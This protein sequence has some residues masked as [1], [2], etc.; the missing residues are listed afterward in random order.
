MKDGSG[1]SKINN[2]KKSKLSFPPNIFRSQRKILKAELNRYFFKY[3][4]HAIFYTPC[5]RLNT[6]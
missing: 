2:N 6:Q 4:T 3:W 1:F 5:S